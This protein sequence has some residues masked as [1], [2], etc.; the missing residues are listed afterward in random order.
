ML[1][2][3]IHRL[4]QGL[5]V[6]FGVSLIVFALSYLGGDPAAA[7]LPLDTPRE[8][9]E[10]FRHAAG[11]DQP[12]PVQYWR[13][14]TRV[15]AGDFGES[16]R[17]REPAM[18]LVLERLPLTATLALLGLFIALVIGV[19]LGIVSAIRRGTRWDFLA[20]LMLLFAQSAP[21]FWLALIFILVF[22][23]GLRW[24]PPSGL[25]GASSLILPALTIGI[26]PAPAI[27]R[28]LRA[29]LV[30]VLTQD[31]IRTAHAK[32]LSPQTVLW[33]HVARNV[34]IPVVTIV[35]LQ[36]S[37]LLGG[38]IITEAVFA[39]PGMGRLTMQ[40]IAARD[41]PL[42]QA[43]V[44]VAAVVVVIVNLALDVVYVWLDPRIHLA[45]Q[46]S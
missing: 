8:D 23:V 29:R 36:L 1:M 6:I 13:F 14:L 19:P 44:F 42:I 9:V 5:L 37:T 26:F 32:G 31:Y 28:L 21:N 3:L 12:L 4:L 11:F 2:Y 18:P 16:L 43:F 33:E 38:A 20:R 40:A 30:Q 24:L 7:L 39:L 45:S 10:L 35:A 46:S 15:A 25:E 22:A 41:V 27:A 34:L 17:Y